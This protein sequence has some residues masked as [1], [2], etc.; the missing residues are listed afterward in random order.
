M[1]FLIRFWYVSVASFFHF[2]FF[3][4]CISPDGTQI[5][6]DFK[7]VEDLKKLILIRTGRSV[8]I[9]PSEVRKILKRK[10]K[11][12]KNRC[13]HADENQRCIQ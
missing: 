1:F 9:S 13:D 6:V 8:G 10:R 5:T 4:N 11:Y 2:Y 3:W 7:S 12:P